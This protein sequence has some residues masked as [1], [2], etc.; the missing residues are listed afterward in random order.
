MDY[1]GRALLGAAREMQRLMD[2]NLK[3]KGLSC[4]QI[5][6]LGWLHEKNGRG[7][8]CNQREIARVCGGVRASSVTSLLKTLQARG[9]IV[10]Q[11]GED[12]REK[13]VFLTGEGLRLAEECKA[14]KEKVERTLVEGFTPEEAN[15]LYQLIER[16][17]KNLTAFAKVE[18][19]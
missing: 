3:K 14:F 4:A 11:T 1:V 8:A 6:V 5:R 12:A 7:E 2:G 15:I 17:G 19:L 13:L 9:L 18:R 16:M 10:R